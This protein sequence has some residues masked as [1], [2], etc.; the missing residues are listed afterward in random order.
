MFRW[1]YGHH[2]RIMSEAIRA[3]ED[4]QPLCG[5]RMDLIDNGVGTRK[6]IDPNTQRL[7]PMSHRN[8]NLAQSLIERK[9]PAERTP[10]CRSTNRRYAFSRASGSATVLEGF[11]VRPD[12]A[13]TKCAN[14]AGEHG[15]SLA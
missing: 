3:G 5:D 13:M 10:G 2:P 12:R 11:G 14:L 6:C 1:V 7:L 4:R 8:C 9:L 15:Y